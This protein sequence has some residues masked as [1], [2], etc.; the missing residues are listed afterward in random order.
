M[1]CERE[2]GQRRRPAKETAC[3]SFLL[4]LLSRCRETRFRRPPIVSVTLNEGRTTLRGRNGSLRSFAL[5]KWLKQSFS[6]LVCITCGRNVFSSS[7]VGRIV[8]ARSLRNSRSSLTILTRAPCCGNCDS[9]GS[10]FPF[11]R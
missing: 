11:E 10:Q 8:S 5:T 3:L 1:L 7:G 4:R 9:S 2:L 6:D